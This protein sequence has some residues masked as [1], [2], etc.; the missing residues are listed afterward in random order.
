MV[1]GSLNGKKRNFKTRASGWDGPWGLLV[2][3]TL[4][5]LEHEHEHEVRAKSAISELRLG[6]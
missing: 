3:L 6:L 2:R 5:D 1:L 4:F